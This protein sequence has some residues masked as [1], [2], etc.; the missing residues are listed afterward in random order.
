LGF[1]PVAAVGKLVQKWERDSYIQKEK[2]YTKQYKKREYRKYKRYTKQ[3]N[4][5]ARNI[6]MTSSV[7][8][9]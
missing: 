6:K 5:H 1:H 2:K 3:E 7:V 4:K 9:K 8:R